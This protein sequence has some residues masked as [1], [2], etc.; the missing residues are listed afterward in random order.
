M[1]GDLAGTLEW[2]H[3]RL[4]GTVLERDLTEL[5]DLYR[6]ADAGT[7][8]WQ[9]R[10]GFVCPPGCGVCC[11]RYDP[12]LL[13]VEADG[14]AAW[15][16]ANRPGLVGALEDPP[17]PAPA[18]GPGGS[19]CPFHD[20]SRSLHCR[21]YPARPLVCRLFGFAGLTG[22]RGETVF[23]SCRQ[24]PPAAAAV[25]PPRMAE[26]GDRLVALC[27]GRLHYRPLRPAVRGALERIGLLLRLTA[28]MDV[29]PRNG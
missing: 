17:S 3:T 9:A 23:R 4:S 5:A 11:G 16:L 2:V 27:G 18:P 1:S 6:R 24:A 7:A 14:L 12:V 8:A 29:P 22:K 19:L 26:S 28:P 10:S 21:V 13:P 20:P 15:L 25:E